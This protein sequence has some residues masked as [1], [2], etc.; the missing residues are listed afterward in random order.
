MRNIRTWLFFVLMGA[1][2]PFGIGMGAQA[3]DG[4]TAEIPAKQLPT[5]PMVATP[6]RSAAPA[7]TRL[8]R[9]SRT[10]NRITDDA[11]WL[12]RNGLKVPDYHFGMAGPD[13]YGDLPR[14]AALTYKGTPLRR[15][16]N[17]ANA[18]PNRF[19]ALYGDGRGEETY[20]VGM[21]GFNG[22]YLYA[23]DFENYRSPDGS[24]PD[25]GRQVPQFAYEDKNGTLYVANGISGYAKEAKGKTG[26]VTALNPKTGKILWRSGPLTQN[27]NTFADAGDVLV[28]GYGFT[29]EPDFVYVLDKRTGRKLQTIPVKSGPSF[30]LRK[31]ERVYVRCYDTDYVFAIKR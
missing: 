1:V 22:E 18:G 30:I 9:M 28:C 13:D 17:T 21:N 7:R 14:G 6:A 23:L 10:A 16:L 15:A 19:L 26:Y 11:A 4:S 29:A 3:Q 12:A 24:S 5:P 20:L 31:G 25:Y 27:A 8:V 2:S